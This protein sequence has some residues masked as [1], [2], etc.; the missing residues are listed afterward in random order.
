MSPGV[1]VTAEMSPRILNPPSDTG[2]SVATSTQLCRPQRT[3]MA[4][5]IRWIDWSES[6]IRNA[7]YTSPG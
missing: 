3:T 2:G 7:I 5:P 4:C 6:L 1:E